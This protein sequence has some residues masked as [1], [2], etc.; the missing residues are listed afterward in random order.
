MDKIEK[1]EVELL[2]KGL[3]PIPFVNS[4][5]YIASYEH[6]KRFLDLDSRN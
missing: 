1:A 6:Y 2:L 3:I 4:V 5:L